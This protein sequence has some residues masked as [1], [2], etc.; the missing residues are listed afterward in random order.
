MRFKLLNVLYNCD[1]NVQLKKNVSMSQ[2]V[3]SI[4][5]M[6]LIQQKNKQGK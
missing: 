3:K 1:A 2:L 5:E 4:L 6:E